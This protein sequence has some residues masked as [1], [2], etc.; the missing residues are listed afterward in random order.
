MSLGDKSTKASS[1]HHNPDDGFD[2]SSV[3]KGTPLPNFLEEHRKFER[4]EKA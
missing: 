3:V 2:M 4:T 1:S